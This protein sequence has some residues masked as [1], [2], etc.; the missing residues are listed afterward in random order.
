MKQKTA[1]IVAILAAA[2]IGGATESVKFFP[3]LGEIATGINVLCL[4]ISS[5]VMSKVKPA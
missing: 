2:L 1:I 4:A 3:S 5:F